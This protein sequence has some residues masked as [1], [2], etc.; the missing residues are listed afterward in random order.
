MDGQYGPEALLDSFGNSYNGSTAART[1]TVTVPAG[2]T[3]DLDSLG[4]LTIN[5]PASDSIS[6][7]ITPTTG[8]PTVISVPVPP[9]TSEI[10]ADLAL[11]AAKASNLSDLGSPTTARTNLGLGTAATHAHGDYDTAGAATAAQAAAVQRANHTG[12]QSA[13]TLVDGTTNKAFLTTERTKLTGIATG[14][15]AN[16]ADA[17][18]LN[19]AN[20]TGTQLMS[21]ISDAGTAAT[22]NSGVANGVASL[23]GAGLV[24]T[25][26][27]PAGTG[28]GV[29]GLINPK[30]APYNCVG[31][32]ITDDTVG[33]QAFF[34]DVSTNKA[35]FLA[36]GRYR[37]TS[38]VYCGW[39]GTTRD[40]TKNGI[41]L[42]G[43]GVKKSQIVVDTEGID[44]LVL[45][46]QGSSFGQ[47]GVDGNNKARH[48]IV[49]KDVAL[50]V[51]SNLEAVSSKSGIG[52]F[53]NCRYTD[54]AY[55]GSPDG[56]NDNFLMLSPVADAC[57][58]LERQIIAV[59]AAT[60]GT[61]TLTFNG[62]TTAPIAFNASAGTVQTSL[63]NLSSVRLSPGGYPNIEVSQGAPTWQAL[64]QGELCGAQNLMTIDGSGLTGGT[65][66]VTRNTAGQI[67]YG[68]YCDAASGVDQG[69]IT[70][71][72][73]RTAGI[74]GTG[75][76]IAETQSI[77]IF[78]GDYE[79]N[80][81]WAMQLSAATDTVVLTDCIITM[82]WMEDNKSGGI[83]YG[84]K[85][86]RNM[87]TNMSGSQ[88]IYSTG[89][90]DANIEIV[91]SNGGMRYRNRRLTG[92]PY[93]VEF[94]V[95]P[96]GRVK[97]QGLKGEALFPLSLGTI[98]TESLS[99]TVTGGVHTILANLSNVQ[100]INL[101]GNLGGLLIDGGFDGEVIQVVLVQD[102]TG[103]RTVA[104]SGVFKFAGGS[105]PVLATAPNKR[106]IITFINIGGGTWY[107]TARA[108]DMG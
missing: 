45:A 29:T 93:S 20:H 18:L 48:C 37:I 33:L 62:Q 44:G 90:T 58:T 88:G 56:F 106:D 43:G 13:D 65:P 40:T 49:Y 9:T 23:D 25:A 30:D 66:S 1:A 6:V 101:Q 5:G 4:N 70:L 68:F 82:P 39:A 74:R 8:T 89:A 10:A 61:F 69:A 22:K 28:G 99:N 100:I 72:S 7:T 47:F 103:N 96:G 55:A 67:G 3:S 52:H 105:A 41:S 97:I 17:A 98:A 46:S 87:I 104:W 73:A 14:A 77:R 81:G 54:G 92:D 19:R 57:G 59:G 21:T 76:Y 2:Y 95:D 53:W 83:L 60:A 102:G 80:Y 35:G 12:T 108:L 94:T 78:G 63:T 38:T 36:P 86:S 51:C 15:T 32:G 64:F 31:D 75:I 27:I 11:K 91:A 42:F 26:Q 71:V 84:G 79:S 16:S 50:G 107:E 85:S 34:D 24:P